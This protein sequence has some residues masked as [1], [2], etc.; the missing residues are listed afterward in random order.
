MMRLVNRV[1]HYA[2]AVIRGLS[3]GRLLTV[4]SRYFQHRRVDRLVSQRLG[5]IVRGGPF[6]GMRYI[7]TP[8]A[9]DLP[10][11]LL[12]CYE[13]ELHPFVEAAIADRPKIILNIGSAEGYYAVGMAYRLPD[14]QVYAYDIDPRARDLC[15]ALS[16]A[17]NVSARIHIKG[18]CDAAELNSGILPDERTLVIMDCEGCEG[19]LLDVAHVPQLAHSSILVEIHDFGETT[20]G[21]TIRQRFAETHAIEATRSVERDP[22]SQPDLQFLSRPDRV[23]A[24]EE[25]KAAQDWYYLR[26]RA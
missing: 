13:L 22:D 20:Y 21:A 18:E 7:Q 11:K 2:G 15:A 8:P 23:L 17:N 24:L 16:V 5:L 19:D 9:H 25:R 3:S 6:K 10:S 4:A 14:V 26:P 12:G 1:L